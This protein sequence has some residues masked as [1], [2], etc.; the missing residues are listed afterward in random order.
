[1]KQDRA[2]EVLSLSVGCG[3][4]QVRDIGREMKWIEKTNLDRFELT[5]LYASVA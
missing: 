5:I 3:E 2:A 1:M 4:R